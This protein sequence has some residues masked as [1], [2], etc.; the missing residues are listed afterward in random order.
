[1]GISLQKIKDEKLRARVESALASAD[2]LQ[3]DLRRQIPGP[4]SGHTPAVKTSPRAGKR[5]R[6]ATKPMLNKLEQEAMDWLNGD[7][8]INWTLQPHAMTLYLANGCKYTV[9]IAGCDP[10]KR[11]RIV[12]WEVKGPKVW[13]D[14]IVKLKVAAHE[15]PNLEFHLIWKENGKWLEQVVLP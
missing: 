15:F 11:P 6:Q 8:Y 14:S 10:D 13:D 4:P 9:D 3:G 12:C 5:I 7:V 2:A 1:M